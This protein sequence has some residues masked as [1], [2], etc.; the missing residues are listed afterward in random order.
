MKGRAPPRLQS[1]IQDR[2]WRSPTCR[3]RSIAPLAMGAQGRDSSRRS[4]PSGGGPARTLRGAPFRDRPGFKPSIVGYL[5]SEIRPRT[6]Q[7][8]THDT[9]ENDFLTL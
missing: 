7:I 3:T 9:S 5:L 4:A 2:A 1:K 8:E 6:T